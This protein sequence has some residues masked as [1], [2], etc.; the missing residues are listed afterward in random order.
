MLLQS[1]FVRLRGEFLLRKDRV[2]TSESLFHKQSVEKLFIW[3][4][5]NVREVLARIYLITEFHFKQF[6]IVI[7]EIK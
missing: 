4:V 7:T 2:C 3:R 6:I 5:S 1:A